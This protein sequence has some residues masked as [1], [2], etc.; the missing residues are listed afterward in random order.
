MLTIYTDDHRL[1]DAK[2]E[3]HH[4]RLVPAFEMPKRA[5]YVI[6]RVREVGLGAV[7]PPQQFGKAPL[8][9]VHSTDFIDFLAGAWEAWTAENG[10][11]EALPGTWPGPGMRRIRP[12][13]IGA[14]LGYY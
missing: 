12:E 14:R 7:E 5:D 4:G 6:G 8:A 1:H 9:R 10:E 13:T 3:L 2:A 11:I